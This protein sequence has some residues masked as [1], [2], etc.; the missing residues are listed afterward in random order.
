[1]RRTNR[2]AVGAVLTVVLGAATGASAGPITKDLVDPATG[3][4]SGWQVTIFEPDLVDVATDLVSFSQNVVVI[5][6]FAEF[7]RLSK[8]GTPEAHL[9]LFQQVRPNAQT[10]TRIAITDEVV[11]NSTGLDWIDFEFL[12]LDSAQV[13][14]D[15]AASA[16]FSI[17]PFQSREYLAGN[18]ILRVFDGLVPDGG[19]WTP[20]R[21]SGALFIA[22]N[23]ASPLPVSF[24]LKELPSIP[25]PGT[26]ALLAAAGGLAVVRRRG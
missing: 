6:K 2:V 10:V 12:V 26:L 14:F 4:H 23:L 1:M 25:A 11:I 9:L 20:G 19:V 22:V 15:P 16:N 5:Q 13:A 8:F 18:T 24:T 17:E 7:E 21:T 3:V